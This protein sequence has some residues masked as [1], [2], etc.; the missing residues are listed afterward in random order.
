M[1]GC[2]RLSPE[3]SMKYLLSFAYVIWCLSISFMTPNT[4]VSSFMTNLLY[5]RYLWELLIYDLPI[6]CYLR[7]GYDSVTQQFCTILNVFC[8]SV[9]FIYSCWELLMYILRCEY[10]SVAEQFCTIVECLLHNHW[11]S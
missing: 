2:T 4:K 9:G 5:Q 3:L 1:Q 10:D 6:T 8:P 7:C 11:L